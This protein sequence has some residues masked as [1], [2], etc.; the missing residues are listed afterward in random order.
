[1]R[2]VRVYLRGI[3]LF[4]AGI[5]VGVFLMQRGAAQE[6]RTPLRLNHVGIAVS[7]YQKSLDFYTKVMGYKIAF[8]FPPSPDGKPTTTYFQIS[9][10]TFL[11]MAPASDKVPAGIT[12]MGI[13]TPDAHA[14][15][16]QLRAAGA[17]VE[18]VRVSG[19]TKANLSNIYDPDHIRLELI[20]LTPDSLHKKAEGS[21][22]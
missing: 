17:H 10:D 8:R 9:R 5:V 13:E 11:E 3:T 2:E 6:P 7:D 21:W 18:D 14:T 19:P 20:E 22:K 4:V 16:M 1:M 12:H 15:V